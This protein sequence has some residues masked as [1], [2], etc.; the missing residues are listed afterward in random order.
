MPLADPDGR[1]LR[2]GAPGTP[3]TAIG[4]EELLAAVARDGHVLLRGY[5]TGLAAFGD[6]VRRVSSR[7]TLDPARTFHGDVVQAID[8]GDHPI[9][10]HA[11]NATTPFAPDL[12]WFYCAR[13][14]RE[15]SQTTIADGHRVWDAL[16]PAARRAF[17]AQ[18]VVFAREV[19]GPIW[20]A[21]VA[22]LTNG[23]K[24]ARDV[25]YE[26]LYRLLGGDPALTLEPRPGGALHYAFR[27]P[28]VHPTR[29][30]DRPAFCNS[31]LTP[32]AEH[33]A[34]PEITFADGT[35]VP[36]GL[37]AEVARTAEAHTEEID[38][39]D[40]DVVVIDNSR[41]MHGRR[42]VLDPLRSL[43]NAQSYVAA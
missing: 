23:A 22:H 36:A 40:G 37:L 42:A 20:R 35:P 30:G 13:A 25:T 2:T 34:R 17:A 32:G 19:P 9:P 8:P 16:P 10:L 26:D 6:L 3:L 43:F 29:F 18:D 39:R 33:Y 24:D 14:A 41:V 11:E 21:M 5:A 38:W 7:T 4:K 15:G 27:T 28:A 1:P 12:V 31:L